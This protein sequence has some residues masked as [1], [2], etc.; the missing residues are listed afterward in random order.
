MDHPAFTLRAANPDDAAAITGMQ[1]LPGFRHG[2]LR[3]PFPRVED[4]KRWLAGLGAADH[5]LVAV[6]GA[7]LVGIAGLRRLDGRR[8]HAGDIGMGVHDDFTGQRIGTGLLAALV[9]MADDWLGLSR[10][11]LTVYTDNL[12]AQALYRRAGFVLEGTHRGYALRRGELVDADF[13]A[14]LRPARLGAQTASEPNN[15]ES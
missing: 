7:Q 3:L 6:I 9:E 12:A 15:H 8:D 11:D 2:T 14:R 10:L 4:T 1:A 13:L 5:V